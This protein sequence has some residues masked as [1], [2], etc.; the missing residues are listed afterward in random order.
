MIF[1]LIFVFLFILLLSGIAGGILYLVYFPIKKKLIKSGKLS[2]RKSNQ[3]NLAYAL[4]IYIFSAY[5]AYT[6][7][8]PTDSFYEN[9]FKTVTFREIPKSAEIVKSTASYPDFHGDYG[10][11]AQIK[12][13]KID[14]K[15]LLKEIS[16]D[17]RISKTNEIIGMSEFDYAIGDKKAKN[18]K[19]KFIRKIKGKN[20]HHLF[21]GFYDDN[22]TIFV[23][24]CIT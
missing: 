5:Q 9:E 7:V 22:Q 12:L 1:V 14:Y 15:K 21:I 23:N 18:I 3:I 17:N 11:S 24:I 4:I 8:Y 16:S 13:T 2:A 6:A 20:N 10:S 19:H